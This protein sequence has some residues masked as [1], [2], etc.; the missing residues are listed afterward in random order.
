VV[1]AARSTR[2]DVSLARRFA[3]RFYYW[4]L[5][6]VGLRDIP[7][8]GADFFLVDRRV[9][10]ALSQFRETNVSLLALVSWLGF[11]Q[12]T[13]WYDKQARLNGRSGWGLEQKMKLV[14]DSVTSFTYAP[15]RFMSYVGIVVAVVGFVYA[16]V[17]LTNAI[18]GSPPEGWSSL[19][20]VVLIVGGLQMLMMGVLGEY[21][22]RTLAEARRR[23]RYLIQ[24]T[25]GGASSAAL[26]RYAA[27]AQDE[28]PGQFRFD[29]TPRIGS[30][31]RALE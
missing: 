19:M 10:D 11:G 28:S 15:I 9:I 2:D 22:W 13:M 6:R 31:G 27:V 4:I 25:V 21:L 23:P 17:V 24:E 16:G 8:D 29:T 20:I 30:S 7:L 12:E 14:V 18:A 5:R 1:W 26:S 3:A